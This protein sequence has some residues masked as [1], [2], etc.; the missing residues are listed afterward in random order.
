MKIG[1]DFS[2]L[3]N[4]S[5]VAYCSWEWKWK[6]EIVGFNTKIRNWIN[7][8]NFVCDAQRVLT[9]CSISKVIFISHHPFSFR[10]S[11]NLPSICW[12]TTIPNKCVLKTERSVTS[13]YAGPECKKKKKKSSPKPHSRISPLPKRNKVKKQC[14]GTDLLGWRKSS[15]NFQTY[16]LCNVTSSNEKPTVYQ[17]CQKIVYCLSQS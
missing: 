8:G 6:K 5:K 17:S 4:F 7:L 1:V 10:F 15:H 9:F 12:V 11:D 2:S 13:D 14:S 3:N 16:F